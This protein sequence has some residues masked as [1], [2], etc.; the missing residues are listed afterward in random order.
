MRIVVSDTS[1][2]IDLH[3]VDLLFALLELPYS[4]VIPDTLFDGELHRLTQAEKDQLQQRGLDVQELDGEGVTC[5]VDY[6]HAHPAL[7][8]NDCFALRMAEQLDD[9]ILMTGDA[10]LRAVATQK[11]I[12]VHGVLWAVDELDLHD[13]VDRTSLQAAMRIFRD[14]TLVFLPLDAL[15]RRIRRFG[16]PRQ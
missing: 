9:A 3:K 13:V 11:A 7:H 1:C 4:F 15:R 5:A 6:F 12:E 2:I 10:N 8:L 16:R 14:D